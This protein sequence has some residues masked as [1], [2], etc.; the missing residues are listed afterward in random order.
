MPDDI[1][2]DMVYYTAESAAPMEDGVLAC[3]FDEP[4]VQRA[5]VASGALTPLTVPIRDG[6]LDPALSVAP[7][8]PAAVLDTRGLAITPH[9]SRVTDWWD[10]SQILGVHYKELRSLAAALSSCDRTAVAAHAL[11][12]Q[13]RADGPRL[14]ENV[15]R[16][17]DAAFTVHNDFC[18]ELKEQ[19][20]EMFAQG[21]PS[22]VSDPV[23]AGGLGI[24]A[25]TLRRGRLSVLNFWRPFCTAPLQRCPLAV[26]DAATIGDCDVVRCRH[27]L[28]RENSSFLKHYRLSVP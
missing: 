2:A 11:R 24:D 14:S 20:L 5:N 4:S 12:K 27:V 22:I 8:E 17:R 21:L 15:E 19:F 7:S 26:L 6:R 16:A 13:G 25:E 23:D 18:D 1:R 10:E 3:P 9:V 28:K